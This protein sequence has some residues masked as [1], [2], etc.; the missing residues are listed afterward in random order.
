MSERMDLHGKSAPP[1]VITHAGKTYSIPHALDV[2]DL[3]D[4]EQV[5]FERETG[6]LALQKS[7]MDPER[8]HEELKAL[9]DRYNG[10]DFGFGSEVTQA[11]FKTPK[12]AALFLCHLLKV[13]EG[14]ML[15]LLF[16]KGAEVLSVMELVTKATFPDGPKG[17]GSTG[18]GAKVADPKPQA[19]RD[20]S[21]PRRAP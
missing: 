18:V 1:H 8:Y 10:G 17:A 2:G 21:A 15:D 9:R 7:A 11:I 13:S 20:R 12:G 4:I 14:E 6:A 16:H 19:R 3:L 5:L